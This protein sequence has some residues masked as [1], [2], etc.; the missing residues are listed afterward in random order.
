VEA[1]LRS[2]EMKLSMRAIC[3]AVLAGLLIP[4]PS[5]ALADFSGCVVGV[6]D[7]CTLTVL[8]RG[9]AE[10]I[11]LRGIDCPEKGQP[12]GTKAKEFTSAMVSGKTVTV[13]VTVT[14][15]LGRTVANVVLPDGRRVNQELVIAGLAWWSRAYAPHDDTLRELE[16]QARTAK[17][18]LW[19]DPR[20]IPPWEWRKKRRR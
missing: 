19:T 2:V 4:L 8:H 12:F 3:L 15:R 11:R 14:D 17:R 16:K 6:T 1:I 5:I 13:H 10:K 18:G 7:G 9:K 20:P